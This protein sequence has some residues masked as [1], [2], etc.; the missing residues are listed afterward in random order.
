MRRCAL[1]LS[2]RLRHPVRI[3]LSVPP[4]FA[5]TVHLEPRHVKMALVRSIVAQSKKVVL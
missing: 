2:Q 1:H 4:D 5:Q 3:H